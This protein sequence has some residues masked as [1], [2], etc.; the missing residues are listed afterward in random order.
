MHPGD[1]YGL[2]SGVNVQLVTLTVALVL[3]LAPLAAEAQSAVKP[4]R[5]G[6]LG[7]GSPSAD[8]PYRE[9]FR[10]GL[11]ERG[12]IEGQNVVIESRWA[13]GRLDRLP[14]LAAELV[15]LKVDVIFAPST[16]STAAA[17]N[18]TRTIPVVM[19]MVGTP[20]ERGTIA[21]LARPGG[22]V[23]GLS[24]NV[25]VGIVGKQLELL[26]EVVP[27]ISR[28]AVLGNPDEPQYGPMVKEAE[29]VG[30]ALGVRLQVLEARG[31]NEFDR[32]FAAMVR[33]RAEALWV[34]SGAVYFLHQRQLADLAAK[35]RL[36]TTNGYREYVDAG[37]LLA[38]GPNIREFWRRAAAYVDKVLQGAKP[39]DLP[40]EQPTKFE[41]VINLKTAKTLGLTIPQSV[42]LRADE[43][44]Q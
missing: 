28:V 6:Y 27:K 36:P 9:T 33:Q 31:P 37:G 40:V 21:S 38:Y 11:R 16:A 13:E 26:K 17:Q 30:R 25:G 15:R 12:W 34:L 2:E 10:E 4:P 1:P 8:A 19:A 22:N 3:L 29:M 39:A 5:V 14:D 23:T 42:L 20:V 44:I 18:A 35:S 7:S 41:L 24:M 43:V 32:A